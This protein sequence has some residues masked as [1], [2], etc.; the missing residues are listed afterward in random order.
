[1]TSNPRHSLPPRLRAHQP[2]RFATAQESTPS[3]SP[4]IRMRLSAGVPCSN[5]AR[6]ASFLN[7]VSRTL[8]LKPSC[9]PS[10]IRLG[11]AETCP[12]SVQRPMQG[13][14]SALDSLHR[15]TSRAG[16]LVPDILEGKGS[17]VEAVRRLE[18][19][20][21]FLKQVEHT[22]NQKPD[23][24]EAASVLRCGR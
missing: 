20:S 15:D 13:F 9:P 2:T 11:R 1:M 7:A 6:G 4:G 24:A 21:I 14:G 19:G 3:P 18:N 12:K 23:M 16:P 8:P 5:S 17:L 22:P 10:R